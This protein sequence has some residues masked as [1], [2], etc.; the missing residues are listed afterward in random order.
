[1]IEHPNSR[2]ITIFRSG[3]FL[4]RAQGA[5][6]DIYFSTSSRSIGSYFESASSP[7]IASGLTFTEEDFLLP[8]ILPVPSTDKEF[9]SVVQKFY[10]DINTKVPYNK[11]VELEIGLLTD[12]TQPVAPNNLP[13]S[14]MDYLRYRH[15]I[16]HPEVA[17]SKELAEGN[18]LI[19]YYIFDASEAIKKQAKKADEKDAAFQLYLDIKPDVRK[20]EMMLTLLGIDPREY[21]GEDR[22]AEMVAALRSKSETD[23]DNFI[24]TYKDNDLEIHYWI[25]TMLNTGVLKNI[26]PKY[27]VAETNKIIGNTLEETTF[28]FKDEANSDMITGLKAMNQEHM[29]KVI[30]KKKARQASAIR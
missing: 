12:N 2:R 17:L 7:R 5:D 9:R 4:S 15:A 21:S 18:S 19:Q 13:I 11:G 20:V 14:L 6:A 28:Y 8:L 25:K 29:K 30:A 24:K 10:I 26:G 22:V 1:M 3:S 16:K 27:V 23:P